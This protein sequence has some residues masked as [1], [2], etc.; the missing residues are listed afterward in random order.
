MSTTSLKAS[1]KR[2]VELPS[3][4]VTEEVT[5]V[6]IEDSSLQPIVDFYQNIK[7]DQVRTTCRKGVNNVGLVLATAGT[8]LNDF[9]TFLKNI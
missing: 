4:T 6:I 3:L 5:P 9:G 8:V 1:P 7:W 2:K